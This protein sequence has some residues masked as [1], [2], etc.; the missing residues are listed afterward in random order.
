MFVLSIT[1][2]IRRGQN[3]RNKGR[4]NIDA[5]LTRSIK[6]GGTERTGRTRE[7]ESADSE[8]FGDWAAAKSEIDGPA[9]TIRCT[10]PG[11]TGFGRSDVLPCRR[12]ICE[13]IFPDIPNGPHATIRMAAELRSSDLT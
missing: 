8:T 3:C 6:A 7:E 13:C 5:K 12:N 1:P 10:Q 4:R 9:I 11:E 2:T